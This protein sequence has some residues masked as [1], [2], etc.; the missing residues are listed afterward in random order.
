MILEENYK[1]I[2]RRLETLG[3]N[4]ESNLYIDENKLYKIYF[5]WLNNLEQRERYVDEIMKL[6]Y[7]KNAIW[8]QDKIYINGIFSGVVIEYKRNF[9]NLA[10][11]YRSLNFDDALTMGNQLSIALKEIHNNGSIIGDI[12]GD[13]IITDK[14]EYYFCDLDG[15]KF[16]MNN[17]KAR[18]LYSL[19]YND[20]NPSIADNQMTDNIKLLTYVLSTM[21]CYNLEDVLKTRGTEFLQKLIYNLQLPIEVKNIM[22]NIFNLGANQPY[23]YEYSEL[24]NNSCKDI[25]YDRLMIRDKIKIL[26]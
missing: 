25:E 16:D 20:R 2:Y 11:I 14:K 6:Q 8:P 3:F 17:E 5:R 21:Y 4:N 22:M 24:L 1:D 9:K 12:H 7:I 19:M 15:M 26:V 23:F 10:N 13:N 18:V